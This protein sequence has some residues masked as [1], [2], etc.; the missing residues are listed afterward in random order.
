L[1][2]FLGQKFDKFLANFRPT[3]FF[4]EKW[5]VQ[6]ILPSQKKSEYALRQRHLLRNLLLAWSAFICYLKSSEL[7]VDSNYL[8]SC[9][10]L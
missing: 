7:K 5:T 8:S 2:D 6:A 3:F 1:S 4:R 9:P 10:A